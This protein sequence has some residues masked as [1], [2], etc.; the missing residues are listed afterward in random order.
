MGHCSHATFY[1]SAT[2]QFNIGAPNGKHED[3]GGPYEPVDFEGVFTRSMRKFQRQVLRHHNRYRRLHG[4]HTLKEDEELN[5]YAQAWALMMAK[6]GLMQHRTRPLH[7]ENLYMWWSSDMQA[8]ITGRMPVEAWYNEI[9]KYNFDQPGFKSGTGHFT[10]LVWKQSRRLGTGIARGRKGTIFIVCVYEP[11]GNIMGQFE[12][13][14]TRPTPGGGSGGGG[15]GGSVHK[16]KR[17]R[18]RDDKDVLRSSGRLP[19]G[20]AVLL[21]CIYDVVGIVCTFGEGEPKQRPLN[22]A[23]QFGN[24]AEIMCSFGFAVASEQPQQ[25]RVRDLPFCLGTSGPS[26]FGCRMARSSWKKRAGLR[27]PVRELQWKHGDEAIVSA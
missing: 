1:H 25:T 13:Q 19:P 21:G 18:N 24:F 27:L 20:V 16:K 10:Q 2:Q 7:G 3:G 17:R 6:K 9:E 22:D 14:V 4:V 8:P 26:R 12:D 11:R 23:F 5:R 15:S